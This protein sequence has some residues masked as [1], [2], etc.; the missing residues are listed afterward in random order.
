MQYIVVKE[1]FHQANQWLQCI[2]I[3]LQLIIVIN[4]ALPLKLCIKISA[5]MI[6]GYAHG[7]Y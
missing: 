1:G 3:T 7:N 4:I 5:A 2:F 6:K